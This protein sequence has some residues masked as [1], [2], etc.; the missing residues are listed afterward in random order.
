M[1]SYPPQGNLAPD[2]ET[3]EIQDNAVTDAKIATHTTTKITV[4][5][6]L[7]GAHIATLDLA[8]QA[9][10]NVTNISVGEIRDQNDTVNSITLAND[11]GLITINQN[12]TF[13]D[14]V[15]LAFNT[16]TGTKFGTATTQKIG[17]YDVTPVIQPTALT[18]V[19]TTL[20]FVNENTPDFSMSSLTTTS[21]AGFST[22]DEAQAFMEVVINMQ[23][24]VGEIE[25]K[26][27][28]LG[29]LA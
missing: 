2:I 24:R 5:Q 15:D 21:A 20:T 7:L 29:L 28:A 17:F 23:L 19:E 26:L 3:A 4:P 22:L 13:D 14:S 10:D 6:S 1:S 16:G 25:T 27:Q 18:T 8:G 9:I 12:V 11:S